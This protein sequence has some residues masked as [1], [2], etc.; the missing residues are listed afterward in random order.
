MY[1]TSPPTPNNPVRMPTPKL[2]T[3]SATISHVS[4]GKDFPSG[5]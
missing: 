3:A 2:I 4:M 5:R 1:S